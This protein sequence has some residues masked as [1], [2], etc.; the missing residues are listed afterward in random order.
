VQV[1]KFAEATAVRAALSFAHE[2]NLDN[3]LVATNCLTVVNRVE[4]KL[5]DCSLNGPIIKDIKNL[6]GTFSSYSII[7][8]SCAQKVDTHCLAHSGECLP[9]SVWRGVPLDYIR[10]TIYIESLFG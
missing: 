3:L 2:E 5:R 8:V 7:H 4:S 1:P 10:Q 9:N 6:I